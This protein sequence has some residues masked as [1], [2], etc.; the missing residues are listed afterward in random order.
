MFAHIAPEALLVS[1]ALLV[2][3][4]RP[5]LGQHWFQKAEHILAKLAR[6]RTLSLFVCGVAAL[7]ARAA[8]LPWL[9]IPHPFINDEFSFLLAGDTFAHGRLA[10]PAHPMWTHLETFH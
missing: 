10:N 6:R 8:V 4:V 3:L 1:L 5:E 2:A 7:V 9:P